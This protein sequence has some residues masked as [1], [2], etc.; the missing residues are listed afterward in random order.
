MIAT[1]ST[2]LHILT[3]TIFHDVE[4]GND[5]SAVRTR[6]ET[7]SEFVFYCL[8]DFFGSKF[9][10]FFLVRHGGLIDQVKFELP[11]PVVVSDVLFFDS[12]QNHFMSDLGGFEFEFERE[13]FV[14]LLFD[15]HAEQVSSRT[16]RQRH[17]VYDWEERHVVF[18]VV[19]YVLFFKKIPNVRRVRIFF[20]PSEKRPRFSVSVYVGDHVRLLVFVE[21]GLDLFSHERHGYSDEG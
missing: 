12:F 10:S 17:D 1:V 11:V 3:V 7:N 6:H 9:R 18:F 14:V 4:R 13:L 2:F 21:K 19:S 16:F 15:E 5:S 8:V 20:E